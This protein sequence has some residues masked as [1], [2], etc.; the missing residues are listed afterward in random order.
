VSLYHQTFVSGSRP[1]KE[2]AGFSDLLHA[3]KKDYELPQ[4]YLE[5]SKHINKQLTL[6][7][8]GVSSHKTHILQLVVGNQDFIGGS[9]KP[10][11]SLFSVDHYNNPDM[12]GEFLSVRMSAG[13][14]VKVDEVIHKIIQEV[15]GS[16]LLSS[17]SDSALSLDD[18]D[19]HSFMYSTEGEVI[20]DAEWV[21]HQPVDTSISANDK[22]AWK[23]QYV[24]LLGAGS[25]G[26]LSPSLAVPTGPVDATVKMGMLRKNIYAQK[27][28]IGSDTTKYIQ[29][30]YNGW[31]A[32]N[33]ISKKAGESQDEDAWGVFQS[34]HQKE[35][36]SVYLQL[37]SRDSNISK[38]VAQR[39]FDL[40]DPSRLPAKKLETALANISKNE[41]SFERVDDFKSYFFSAMQSFKENPQESE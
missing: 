27:E 13:V 4:L 19:W 8:E 39:L 11:V 23:L 31:Q 14:G 26:L 18:V 38:E 1:E 16:Q 10:R 24:R 25:L 2:D 30:K 35:F 22:P 7:T 6:I 20:I 21:K 41:L 5:Q 37:A 12:N 28:W 34:E 3:M 29:T 32:A 15:N 33:K 40:T 9:V 17:E 36:K